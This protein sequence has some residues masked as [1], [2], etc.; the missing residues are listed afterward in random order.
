MKYDEELYISSGIY[1]GD[2]DGKLEIRE[3]KIVRCRKPHICMSCQREIAAGKHAVCERGFLDNKP[4]S[5]YTCLECIE[6]WLKESG[7]VESEVERK[8][9]NKCIMNS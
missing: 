3:E 8:N 5:G 7:Q 4:V 9:G 2:M 6:S 1:A